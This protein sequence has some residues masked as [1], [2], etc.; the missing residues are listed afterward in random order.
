VVAGR[1]RHD[2]E[3]IAQRHEK[4]RRVE[5]SEQ[6]QSKPTLT[7]KKPDE[8]PQKLMH[9]FLT[10]L[11]IPILSAHALL[12]KRAPVLTR[13]LQPARCQ[14]APVSVLVTDFTK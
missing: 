4:E 1:Q 2:Q 12:G 8:L 11:R 9:P 13:G 14:I 5:D 6:Q 7:G 3:V 10:A